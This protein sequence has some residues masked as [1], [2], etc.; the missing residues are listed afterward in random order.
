M[1]RYSRSR[2]RS[3]GTSRRSFIAGGLLV[4]G[5]GAL[6]L[7]SGAFSQVEAIRGAAIETA[8]DENGLLGIDLVPVVQAGDAGQTIAEVTN[9]AD[10]P[11]A[12][13]ASLPAPQAG[14][15]ASVQ[16]AGELLPGE[17]ATVTADVAADRLYGDGSL[18]VAFAGEGE[19]VSIDLTRQISVPTLTWFV[20]D[21]TED[22]HVEF[23]VSWEIA[24]VPGAESATVTVENLDGDDPETFDARPLEDMATYPS[25]GEPEW[26]AGGSTYQVT[27]SAFA[28]D[29]PT[30]IFERQ[31]TFE[32][33]GE[34]E[35]EGDPGG[36]DS[37]DLESFYVEDTI[38]NSHAANYTVCYEVSHLD[39]GDYVE[40]HFDIEGPASDSITSTEA[41]VGSVEYGPQPGT[42]DGD[43]T[44]T[45][46]VK[47][48]SGFVYDSDSRDDIA[49][50]SDP[51]DNPDTNPCE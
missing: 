18:A 3:T 49:N 23:D 50:D 46:E 41:P 10:E 42:V 9:N 45:V 39:E 6:T 31:I 4:A 22:T 51:E 7:Q 37:P 14:E 15:S 48:Q 8:T 40:V 19:D 11:I 43:F 16:A 13:S 47:S 17:S 34:P 26:G 5:G 21:R 12:P 33:D 27:F 1:G 20:N 28:E 38:V 2:K 24:N 32:A 35:G 30:P 36:E 25:D 44:I 29:T